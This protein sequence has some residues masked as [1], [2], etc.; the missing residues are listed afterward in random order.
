L[1]PQGLS[2]GCSEADPSVKVFSASNTAAVIKGA[3]LRRSS[4]AKE[5]AAAILI[6]EDAERGV[7]I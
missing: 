7:L 1:K 3:S 2:T 6:E 4:R 5:K